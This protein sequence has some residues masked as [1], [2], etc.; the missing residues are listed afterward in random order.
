MRRQVLEDGP[1]LKAND[2]VFLNGLAKVGTVIGKVLGSI[3]GLVTNRPRT[4]ENA[5]E[6]YW[7]VRPLLN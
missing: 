6:L 1:A 7:V 3:C 4:T 2:P 5:Y